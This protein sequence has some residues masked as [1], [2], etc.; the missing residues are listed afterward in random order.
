MLKLRMAPTIPISNNHNLGHSDFFNHQ[1]C[2]RTHTQLDKNIGNILIQHIADECSFHCVGVCLQCLMD[3]SSMHLDYKVCFQGCGTFHHAKIKED[4]FIWTREHFPH[5]M[6]SIKHAYSVLHLFKIT[7]PS[8]IPNRLPS[9]Q[10]M[11]ITPLSTQQI[12]RCDPS[13][14]TG[15]GRREESAGGSGAAPPAITPDITRA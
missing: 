2:R 3:S 1:K 12:L 15:E 11:S 8:V 6:R 4:A 14:Q 13:S 9:G 7:K 10:K 5:H